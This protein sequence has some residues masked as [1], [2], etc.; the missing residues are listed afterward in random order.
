MTLLY[1][2]GEDFAEVLASEKYAIASQWYVSLQVVK[3]QFL[4]ENHLF[5]GLPAKFLQDG[6]N[7]S[8]QESHSGLW[9]LQHS[10]SIQQADGEKKKKKK[11]NILWKAFFR[12]LALFLLLCINIIIKHQSLGLTRAL[13]EVNI[14]L[15][16][17]S[18]NGM[19]NTTK[20]LWPTPYKA[21]SFLCFWAMHFHS[22]TPPK[23]PD[24][25]GN[26]PFP[27]SLWKQY[28]CMKWDQ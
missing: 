8:F 12:P 28:F 6:L 16:R 26:L 2:E 20:T 21:L 23:L 22:Q 13:Q 9:N 27:P 14:D 1:G 7:W 19:A 4:L 15:K 11:R 3:I 25:Y 24:Y 17:Q 10:F 5:D 18:T